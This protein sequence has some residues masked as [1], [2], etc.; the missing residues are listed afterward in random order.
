VEAAGTV[1]VAGPG[2]RRRIV[3]LGA[4]LMSAVIVGS[5]ATYYVI[6]RKP[7]PIPDIVDPTAQLPH[8]MYSIYGVDQPVGV[9]VT[10]DG[11]RIYVTEGAGAHSLRTLDAGGT[12]ITE[13]SPTGTD[14]ASRVPVYD[15]RDPL[16]GEIYVSDR[17]RFCIDIYDANGVY[18]RT[19]SKPTGVDVWEPLGLAFATDGTLYV[20]DVAG[21]EHRVLA[22]DR[23]GTVVDTITTEGKLQYPNGIAPVSDAVYVTDSNNG[24]L[25]RS[26]ATRTAVVIGR[27]V[28]P[29]DL[30]LPRGITTDDRGRMYVVD[31]TT[32]AVSVYDLPKDGATRPAYVGTFGTEGRDDGQ[33]EFPNAVAADGRGHL[34]ISDGQN[35][36]IQVWGY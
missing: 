14:D 13:G 7:L 31:V 35:N 30:G 6:T 32:H 18:Q 26:D 25:V 12:T 1:A 8:Y 34:F 21:E 23:T 10:D 15:A 5:T 24:Q 28:A 11:G 4:V 22:I 27:G 19:M 17:L 29:G 16:T 20:S 9:A 2:R 36:R 33:F 3:L